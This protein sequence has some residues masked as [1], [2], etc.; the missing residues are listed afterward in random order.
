MFTLCLT[1]CSLVL[2]AQQNTLEEFW[3]I[4]GER[5]EEMNT[6][7]KAENY[8]KAENTAFLLFEAYD[9]LGAKDQDEVRT[10]QAYVYY[11]LACVYALSG[12]SEK[13]IA[14]FTRA[15]DDGY[16]NHYG[17]VH[18]DDFE[19]LRENPDFQA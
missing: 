9:R 12:R 7:L 5:Y 17:A 13:A 19:S 8:E 4:F 2:M 15:I 3:D 10:T 11:R 16:M 18:D 6:A 14:M 1:G